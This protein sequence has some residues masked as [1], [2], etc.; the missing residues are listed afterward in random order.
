MIDI[1]LQQKIKVA[2]DTA[3]M[4]LTELGLKMGMSQASISK[5][6]KTGK[7]DLAQWMIDFKEAGCGFYYSKD[8]I[9][10]WRVVVENWDQL[11]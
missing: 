2:C 7:C 3:G 8:D 10:P 9:E 5:R 6:V 11:G 4:S 1:T